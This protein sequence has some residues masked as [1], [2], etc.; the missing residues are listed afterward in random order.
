M[1]SRHDILEQTEANIQSHGWSAISVFADNETG[2]PPF[3]YSAG[4]GDTL[5]CPEILVI[6]L[7]PRDAHSIIG[8]MFDAIKDSRVTMGDRAADYPDVIET[9]NV[10]VTP[11]PEDIAKKL[12]RV[13]NSRQPT[14]VKLMH[15]KIPDANGILPGDAGCDE[16]YAS[17]QDIGQFRNREKDS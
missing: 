8:A 16:R 2:E 12:A 6:G 1:T 13:S 17:R 15:L 14:P 4:F 5:G 10:R 9:F 11:V 3:T 7:D